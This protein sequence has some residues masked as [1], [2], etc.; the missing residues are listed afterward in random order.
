MRVHWQAPQLYT[1]DPHDS[2][3]DASPARQRPNDLLTTVATV[4][5]SSEEGFVGGLT[6]D[7]DDLLAALEGDSDSDDQGQ[8]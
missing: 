6:V 3:A 4:D 1:K 8:G 7:E 5:S 2:E